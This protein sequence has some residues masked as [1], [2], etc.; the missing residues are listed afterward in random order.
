MRG[1]W[2]VYVADA[3]DGETAV[4]ERRELEVLHQEADRVFVRGTL[5][6]GERVVVGGRHRLVPGQRVRVAPA[7]DALIAALEGKAR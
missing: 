1:L 2:A 5:A 4:L 3:A 6:D 7:P